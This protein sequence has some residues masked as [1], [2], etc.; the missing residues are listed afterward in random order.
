MSTECRAGLA[1]VKRVWFY[2]AVTSR[3]HPITSV[4]AQEARRLREASNL[5]T[6]AMSRRLRELGVPW[7]QAAVSRFEAGQR[8][9]V[10]VHELLALALVLGTTPLALFTDPRMSRPVPL[11][12]GFEADPWTVALWCRGDGHNDERDPRL[13]VDRSTWVVFDLV[14]AIADLCRRLR[15]PAEPGQ[16]Q[17]AR[18]R[19]LLRLLAG[20]LDQAARLGAGPYPVPDAVRARAVELDMPLH[21]DK[22]WPG[23][24]EDGRFLAHTREDG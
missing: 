24:G 11:A 21:R 4:I 1:D 9:S 14:H 17:D 7:T 23:V 12:D 13:Q 22:P 8:E 20:E 2:V 3:A 5:S 15:R 18:D 19:S 16:D 10:G 6:A